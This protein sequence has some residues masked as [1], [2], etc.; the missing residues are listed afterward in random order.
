MIATRTVPISF[1]V[2]K[3]KYVLN[4]FS[5]TWW[6]TTLNTFLIIFSSFA[7]MKMTDVLC[8]CNKDGRCP[9]VVIQ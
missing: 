1:V 5:V 2:F 9:A 4:V 8:Q 7:S 3:P 6:K